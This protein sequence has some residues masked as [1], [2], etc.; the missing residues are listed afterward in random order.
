MIMTD[1][2]AASGSFGVQWH[3]I[4]VQQKAALVAAHHAGTLNV[5]LLS[6]DGATSIAMVITEMAL[7]E[8]ALGLQ[9]KCTLPALDDDSDENVLRVY[10][11][12][13][14]DNY[15][16]DEMQRWVVQPFERVPY[17]LYVALPGPPMTYMAH[18]AL[19]LPSKPGAVPVASL[20]QSALTVLLRQWP[21]LSRTV[22]RRISNAMRLG[23]ADSLAK[24]PRDDDDT[25][26]DE[27][28]EPPPKWRRLLDL[29]QT[30]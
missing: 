14:R 3:H 8:G 22:R 23:L 29:T 7:T 19:L 4:V 25:L 12:L 17:K 26:L 30:Q 13:L 27:P 2:R 5:K 24:R 10:P 9:F 16:V 15:V 1:A 28:V 6:E 20:A 11:P 18:A 21:Q